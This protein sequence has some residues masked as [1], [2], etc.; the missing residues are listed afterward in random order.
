MQRKDLR[1]ETEEEKGEIYDHIQTLFLQ[2]KPIKLKLHES[3]FPSVTMD[4][5]K[6]HITTD[7]SSVE[8]WWLMKIQQRR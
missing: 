1:L 5:Y 3:G 2:G 8:A 4:C 6:V 7:W